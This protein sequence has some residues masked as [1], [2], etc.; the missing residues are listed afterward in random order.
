MPIN[1]TPTFYTLQHQNPH[2]SNGS[3]WLRSDHIFRITLLPFSC[4]LETQQK[5]THHQLACG[6]NASG[7]SSK[8]L[9]HV[10][11]HKPGSKT[12]WWNCRCE[13]PMV[14]WHELYHH[15]WSYE[16]SPHFEQKLSQLRK[17]VW[18]P[19]DFGAFRRWDYQFWLRMVGIS[20]K[21]D[22]FDHKKQ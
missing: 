3:T 5:L 14:Y 7:A 12:L 9:A 16:C 15:Q 8:R 18:N 11:V 17:R 6:G 10:R 1:P 22:A 20:E 19:R 4:S 13:R 21:N 2:C